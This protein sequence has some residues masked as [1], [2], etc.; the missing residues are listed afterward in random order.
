MSSA[1]GKLQG[2]SLRGPHQFDMKALASSEQLFVTQ[3]VS[4]VVVIKVADT[5]EMVTATTN[6]TQ[7]ATRKMKSSTKIPRTKPDHPRT[8]EMVRNAIITL[9]DRGGSS[10]QAIKKFIAA[11]YQ[12]DSEK[13]SPFIK[14]YLKKAVASG[15]LVQ[16]KGKG[17]CGSFRLAA[18]KKGKAA[19]P[20]AP[21]RGRAA[22]EWNVK[23]QTVVKGTKAPRKA[24]LNSAE[25]KRAAKAKKSPS[26]AKKM[27]KVPTKQPKA[28]RP[29]TAAKPKTPK[30]TIPK[31]K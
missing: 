16:T 30:K 23:K 11:N 22:S 5:A 8:S 9:K 13:I 19:M 24:A 25:K 12:L 27:N 21:A 31:K 18:V 4:R 1:L 10:V 7:V 28:P 2:C 26:K 14:R 15:L 6:P 17:A 3:R 29:K 20:T